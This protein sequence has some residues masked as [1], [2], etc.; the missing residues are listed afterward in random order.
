MAKESCGYGFAEAANAT[1][2]FS[3]VPT[4]IAATAI[5]ACIAANK[6]GSVSGAVPTAAINRVPKD[7]SITA[8]GSATIGNAARKR[9]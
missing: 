2:S 1:R 7:A 8:T 9:A 4:A 6:L 3:S 5:A